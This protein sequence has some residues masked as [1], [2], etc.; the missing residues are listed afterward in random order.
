MAGLALVVW[1]TPR[2]ATAQLPVAPSSPTDA[3]VSVARDEFVA[4]MDFARQERWGPALERFVRSYAL[5]GSPVALFNLASTLRSLGRF[6][7]A[8]EAFARLLRDPTLD[9][10]TRRN[11]AQM[12]AELAPQIGVIRVE[13]VP[14]GAARVVADGR[15]EGTR[16]SRPIEITLEP[17]THV[18]SVELEER[19]PWRWSGEVRGGA[20]LVLTADFRPIEAPLPNSEG[21]PLWPWLVGV[22]V[23]LV[24]SAVVI[25]VVADQAAQLGPR[26]PWVI[27]LP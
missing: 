10:E 21:I 19:P 7:E 12:R 4:G 27:E 15:S 1:A 16:R 18:L 11:T 6:R 24:L 14:E 3:D 25:G 26:S 17:G 23:V 20:R 2:L 5:S 9:D 22:G 8:D 13:G